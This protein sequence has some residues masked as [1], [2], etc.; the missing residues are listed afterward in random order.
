[1]KKVVRLTESDLTRVIKQIVSEQNDKTLNIT[2]P[3]KIGGVTKSEILSV[4]KA[5][6]KVWTNVKIKE[7]GILG[8]ETIKYIKLFQSQNGLPENGGIGLDLKSKLLPLLINQPKGKDDKAELIRVLR[9][10]LNDMENDK[11]DAMGVAQVIYNDCAHFINKTDIFSGRQG[12]VL[13]T[14]VPFAPRN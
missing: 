1:M 6:N 5:L 8:P 13:S 14:K 4:Q 11:I 10:H 12:N 3:D 2:T 9:N 7:D